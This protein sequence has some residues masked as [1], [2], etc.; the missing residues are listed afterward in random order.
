VVVSSYVYKTDANGVRL[1]TAA[2]NTAHNALVVHRPS[3]ILG[4][5]QQVRIEVDR[6]ITAQTH[7]I[8]ASERIALA[9][10]WGGTTGAYAAVYNGS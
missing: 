6:D 1:T 5:R 2:S 8:V 4:E 7:K 9:L 3:V 10:P